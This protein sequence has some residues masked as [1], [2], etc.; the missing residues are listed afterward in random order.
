MN[1]LHIV[2]LLAVIQF[3]FFGKLVG[4]ARGKYGVKA[5]VVIGPEGFERAF[6]V[7]MNTLEQLVGF[8]PALFI[9]GQHW[10]NGWVAGVGVIYLVGR[11]IYWRSYVA[12]P[13]KRGLGFGLTVLST[14][15]LVVAG[16]I[17]AILHAAA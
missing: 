6:R 3:F 14:F 4:R 15:L 17:G 9:A 11:L 2:A 8:L 16:L 10:S 7:H 13:A 5:P 1:Y 12:D